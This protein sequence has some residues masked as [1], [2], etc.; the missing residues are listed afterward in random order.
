MTVMGSLAFILLALA[1][2]VWFVCVVVGNKGAFKGWIT[3]VAKWT[4]IVCL[5]AF[6]MAHG[7]ES[8]FVT[9]A[10]GSGSSA[11]HK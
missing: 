4:F 10:A 11:Q 8:C 3:E 2:I 9:A 7:T 1:L 6:A 5:L